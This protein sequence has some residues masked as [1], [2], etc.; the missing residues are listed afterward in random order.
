MKK[1]T[2][3]GIFIAA[4][5][6]AGALTMGAVQ[7]ASSQ[8]APVPSVASAVASAK[9]GTPIGPHGLNKP[10]WI[11]EATDVPGKP[12][13]LDLTKR[14]LAHQV[15]LEKQGIMFG[16]GPLVHEDGSPEYGMIVIRAD[17]AAEARR[18]A[19]SDPM[20]QSGHRTYTLHK[21]TLNEGRITLVVNFSDGT[22]ALN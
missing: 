9:P 19:D 13:D 21:W 11:I 18:I 8:S 2:Q 12:A 10:L 6:L 4:A 15:D 1:G 7:Q 3:Q 16:A 14:H 22:Y 17:S 20:H 5:F